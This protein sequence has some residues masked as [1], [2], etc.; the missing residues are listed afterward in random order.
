[1]KEGKTLRELTDNVA[2]QF[3]EDMEKLRIKPPTYVPRSST[4]VDQAVQLII[5]LLE[6]GYAYWDGG[7]VFYDPLKFRD[8]GRLYGLD[9]SRW[10]KKKRH[11]RKDTYPGVQWNLGDFILWHGY[12]PGDP[13]FLD[14]EI[15][16]GRPAW[17]VQDAAMSTKHLGSH[18]DV[19]CGGIDNL[20]RHHDYTIAVVE[21]VYG[22]EYA[23]YWLYGEHLLVERKKMSKSKGNVV[24]LDDLLR[25]GF[26]PE[27]VRFHLIYR[28]YRRKLNFTR[29]GLR[30]ASERLDEFQQMAR[31]FEGEQ[32][33]SNSS[34]KSALDLIASIT[35]RFEDSMNNDLDV[36]HAFDGLFSTMSKLYALKKKGGLGKDELHRITQALR[37]VDGVIQCLQASPCEPSSIRNETND[38]TKS[39]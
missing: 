5:A 34:N 10:P 8:F 25:E 1:V 14:T 27:H 11:F 21:A 37:M 22:G 36:K 19:C 7:N 18:I 13:F 12:R 32:P 28:H 30:E 6:K 20:Y 17:N 16:R 15:G 35:K 9:M 39:Y 26:R 33:C 31:S 38:L 24:Y 23:H 29:Y 3:F 2:E 4:S